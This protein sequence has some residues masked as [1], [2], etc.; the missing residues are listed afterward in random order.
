MDWL[1]PRTDVDAFNHRWFADASGLSPLNIDTVVDS[2]GEITIDDS[3]D[4]TDSNDAESADVPAQARQV[5]IDPYLTDHPAVKSLADDE[6]LD[7]ADS[8]IQ[9]RFQFLND[10]LEKAICPSSC[11]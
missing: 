5:R 6:Q 10:D 3:N 9:R 11:D 2:S 7:L 4:E 1:G 8:V